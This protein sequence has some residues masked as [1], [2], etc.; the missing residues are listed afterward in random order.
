MQIQ[1]PGVTEDL[2]RQ[3]QDRRGRILGKGHPETLESAHNLAYFLATLE[4]F[5]EAEIIYRQT[6]GRRRKVLGMK[7]PDTLETAHQLG[8]VLSMQEK[9]EEAERMLRQT[10]T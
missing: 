8:F 1:D 6:L 10:Y 2:H 5:E 3:L 7:H 4:N 9:Y